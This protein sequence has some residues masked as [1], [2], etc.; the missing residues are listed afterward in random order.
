MP[1]KQQLLA[2]FVGF[3]VLTVK[4][5]EITIFNIIKIQLRMKLLKQATK[6]HKAAAVK[7][8]IQYSDSVACHIP[9]F[10][11]DNITCFCRIL[12]DLA[13]GA[14][15]TICAA[16]ACVHFANVNDWVIIQAANITPKR[17]KL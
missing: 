12:C 13:H 4:V 15:D 3:C 10:K 16:T 9:I 8:L 7:S 17:C 14:Y 6:R 5:Y 11:I 2:V 1:Q